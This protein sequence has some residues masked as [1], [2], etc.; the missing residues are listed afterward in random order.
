MLARVVMPGT[1]PVQAVVIAY[2]SGF[3]RPDVAA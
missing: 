3:V 2:E 1:A